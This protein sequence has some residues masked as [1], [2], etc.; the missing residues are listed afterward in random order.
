MDAAVLTRP[1]ECRGHG[2]RPTDWTPE[3]L[4]E[5]GLEGGLVSGLGDRG[6]A[7]AVPRDEHG[8]QSRLDD[9]VLVGQAGRDEGIRQ[10]GGGRRRS[11]LD[12]GGF[13]QRQASVVVWVL[14]RETSRHA[15][16]SS[17]SAAS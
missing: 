17:R 3:G 2:G 7:S 16:S 14:G 1:A 5:P 13:D 10:E 6:Y 8:T 11:Q 4:P 15:V 12:K 9:G